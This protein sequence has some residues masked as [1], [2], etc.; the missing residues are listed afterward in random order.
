MNIT[1]GMDLKL[2]LLKETYLVIKSMLS[3]SVSQFNYP[4]KNYKANGNVAIINKNFVI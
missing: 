3:M 4:Y 1:K 2:K